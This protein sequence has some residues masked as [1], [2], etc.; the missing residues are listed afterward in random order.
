MHARDEALTGDCGPALGGDVGVG[1]HHWSAAAERDRGVARTVDGN[2]RPFPC[3]G[4][5][6][7]VVE[8]Q[9]EMAPG[10]VGD[11]DPDHIRF[12][13]RAERIAGGERHVCDRRL[14]GCRTGD[15]GRRC[16][17][18][19]LTLAIR[20]VSSHTEDAAS[21]VDEVVRTLRREV[22][23]IADAFFVVVRDTGP[24]D[25]VVVATDDVGGFG[26]Q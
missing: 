3:R 6:N 1:D 16:E 7:A 18:G 13:G 24:P 8:H 17:L 20:D 22:H 25:F 21:A 14:G 9:I 12:G 5:Q 4:R 19:L 11:E 15:G 10:F 26:R 2:R 23:L